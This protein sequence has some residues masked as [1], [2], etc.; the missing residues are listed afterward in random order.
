MYTYISI[1]IYSLQLTICIYMYTYSHSSQLTVLWTRISTTRQKNS[2]QHAAIRCNIL[3]HT[4]T[5]CEDT[6]T[7]CSTHKTGQRSDT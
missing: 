6:A 5:Y 3:P 7:L 1:Y 4:V 2:L